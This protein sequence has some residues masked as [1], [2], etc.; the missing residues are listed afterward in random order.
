MRILLHPGKKLAALSLLETMIAT[1]IVSLLIVT[2]MALS[3]YT[4]RSFAAISNYV[5]LDR[6]SRKALDRL[7]LMIREADGVTSFT[8]NSV[9]LSYHSLPL[10][11]SYS[12]TA[13]AFT[14]TWNGRTTTLL[15]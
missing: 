14:E 11:Y 9:Q 3:S 1:L 2:I 13:K 4:A 12:P 10:T 5:T 8:T 6:A 15:Q 7:T